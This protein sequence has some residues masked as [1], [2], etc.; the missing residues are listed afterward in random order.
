VS[1]RDWIVNTML[2]LDATE[3]EVDTAARLR[4]GRDPMRG[5]GCL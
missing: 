5:G 3:G 1:D 4:P 2:D